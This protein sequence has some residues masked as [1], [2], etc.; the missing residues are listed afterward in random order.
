MMLTLWKPENKPLLHSF[1]LVFRGGAADFP[2]I[3]DNAPVT[4]A[5]KERAPSCLITVREGSE[6]LFP[7]RGAA[8]GTLYRLSQVHSRYVFTVEDNSPPPAFFVR[9]G[10][11]L[12]TFS[13]AA[14]LAVTVADCLPVFLL[15]MDSGAFAVLHSGW[16]GT[17]IVLAALEMLRARGTRPEALAAV[18]GPCIRGCCYRVD[19]ARARSYENEFGEESAY[20]PP[21]TPFPLGPVVCRREDGPYIDMQAA[22]ARLLS[23]AGVRHIAWCT[24]C[25]FTDTRLGSYR[26]QGAA[27]YTRMIAAAGRFDPA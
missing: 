4:E 3:A 9:P 2:F 22:N 26:R 12:V 5:A 13:R 11:G 24:D 20:V 23:G 15:D 21:G 10:D 25:T 1:P 14:F 8:P 27:A 16:R 17:G 7:S 6:V 18:L 19:E